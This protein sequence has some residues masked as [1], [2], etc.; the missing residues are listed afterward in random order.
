[1]CL[2]ISL[3]RAVMAVVTL[4]SCVLAAFAPAQAK[5]N[6][7]GQNITAISGIVSGNVQQ[8]GFRALIQK[9]AIAYNLAGSA[10]N[11][12]DNTVRF[13]LQG[14]KDRVDQAVAAIRDGTKKS[15][16]VKVSLSPATVAPNLNTFTVVSWTSESR[17]IHNPYDLVF[18]LRADNT[19]IKRKAVKAVWSEICNNTVKGEDV[20]KCD[21]GDD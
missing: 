19:T 14:D 20:G 11:K 12:D 6:L 5:S 13:T 21:K 18:T 15:S 10:E 16:D 17:N 4:M 1:M 2:R 8:V 9:Q 7:G 3:N